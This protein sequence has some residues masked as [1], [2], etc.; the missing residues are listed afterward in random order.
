MNGMR[1]MP[2][3]YAARYGLIATLISIAFVA[4][5]T[6]LEYSEQHIS[7]TFIQF[8]TSSKWE[9]WLVLTMPITLIPLA[10]WAGSQRD[11]VTASARDREALNHI[12]RMLL[13]TPDTD[14][15][16]T[17]P[18]LLRDI[19]AATGVDEAS[20]LV[21]QH[22][23]WISYAATPNAPDPAA[24]IAQQLTW[25]PTTATPM[26]PDPM[27]AGMPS[28]YPAALCQPIWAEAQPL[29]WLV[30]FAHTNQSARRADNEWL[31]TVAD[32]IGAALARARQNALIRRRARD[33]E[34]L[35]QINRTLLAGMELDT[36]LDAIVSSA[37][38]RFGLPYV[39]VMWIDTAAGEF[40][41]RAQ[42]GPLR[43]S[44]IPNFRQ[45]LTEG[46]AAVV[47]RT[48]Q[49]Y[50]ARDTQREPAYIPP[51]NAEIRSLLLAP[52]NV[53]G[54]VSGVMTF[55]SLGVDAFSAED[56]AALT[57]LADQAAIAAENARL[58]TTAQLER[59]RLAA[60]LHSTRDVVLLI[61]RANEVQLLNPA[62]EQ[63]IGQ[64]A[65]EV[66]GH[67]IDQLP[68]LNS[69][70]GVTEEQSFEAT[71]ENDLTYLVTVNTAHDAAGTLFGRVVI[72]RDITYLKQLDQFKTQMMQLASHDL[73]APLGVAFGYL[74][75][76]LED[77]QPGT[78][79]HE[80]ALHG[81]EAALTRM[82]TLVT[83]LLDLDHIESGLDQRSEPIE[84]AALA[85][86]VVLDYAES[87]RLRQQQLKLQPASDLPLIYGD[88]L[89]LKL[90]LGNL[91]SNAIKYTPEG[92]QITVR[93]SRMGQDL[94]IEVQDTGY[95][96]PA[97]AQAKLFQR[98][99]RAKAPGTENITGTGLGLSLAKAVIDQ[100][101]GKITV[102]SETGQGS[103]FQ[104]WL[105]TA[106][107]N[108]Q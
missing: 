11:R 73:R 103:T 27:P 21:R 25:P 23:Q 30:L 40:F 70:A 80:Q 97:A 56:V 4:L 67:P 94:L 10:Y 5:D 39:T 77:L 38:V 108:D 12:L 50:L 92:G 46:L 55:E 57:V 26:M 95:G 99:F 81:I 74:D 16:R 90:A 78:S 13:I 24:D 14:L 60:I 65:A 1:R 6:A 104:V 101:G 49:P 69:V 43:A 47:L 58:L 71:L 87:A 35:A 82:Q 84:V 33:L 53:A 88:P 44:A 2:K 29:G 41:L 61:D 102:E 52:L 22:E 72:M 66:I 79:F 75:V 51:V 106:I 100:H 107:N 45:K 3:S 32:Q 85:A 19:T 64:A 9:Y 54:Q 68:P 31:A 48:G 20:V 36:L 28:A 7:T 86:A 83:E 18:Q 89:R 15:D 91:I 42:A 63:L 96:I 62:A 17:L 37:Q 59:Q 105:P 93:A 34:A 8:L 98:F 76:L